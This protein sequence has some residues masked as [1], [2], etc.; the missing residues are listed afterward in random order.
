MYFFPRESGYAKNQNFGEL[1]AALFSGR[2]TSLQSARTGGL[3][4]HTYLEFSPSET[5]LNQLQDQLSGGILKEKLV[6]L[7]FH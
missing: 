5:G 2:G 1:K 3:S 7:L 4:S 6:N